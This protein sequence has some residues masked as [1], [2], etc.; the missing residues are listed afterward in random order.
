M[1]PRRRGPDHLRGLLAATGARPRS[2]SSTSG[3]AASSPARCCRR[4]ATTREFVED[5]VRDHRRPRH[6][7]GG[8]LPRGRAGARRRPA[9]AL[10][11]RRHRAGVGL[12]RMDPATSTATGSAAEIVPELITEAAIEIATAEL[13]RSNALLKTAVLPVTHRPARPRRCPGRRRRPVRRRAVASRRP[14][15]RGSPSRRP[16]DRA[17]SGARCRTR[18][19]A[20]VDAAMAA[21]DRAFRDGAVAAAHT[22]PARASTCCGWPTSWRSGPRRWR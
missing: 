2:A 19:P 15:R 21:A 3:R 22:D 9:V 20:D 12:V 18:T 7:P 14:A 4:S 11:P 5:V 8:V 10:R 16:R 6:P 17:R 13:E 1:G